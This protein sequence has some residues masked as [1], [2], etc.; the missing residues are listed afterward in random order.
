MNRSERAANQEARL[1]AQ[2]AALT[3]A[4]AKTQAIQRA[5]ERKQRDKRR[6]LVGKLLDEAGLLAWSDADLQAVAQA[7][8][9][10]V[11]V[12][13]PGALVEGLLDEAT[14]A[15]DASLDGGR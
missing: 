4:M 5:E 2:R 6:Y 3:K 8:S 1:R 7:L 10:L 13:N 11:E 9:R 14:L 15:G 12:P